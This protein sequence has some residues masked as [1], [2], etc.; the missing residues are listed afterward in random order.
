M[1]EIKDKLGLSLKT[2]MGGPQR[3]CSA[4]VVTRVKEKSHCP[5][6]DHINDRPWSGGLWVHSLEAVWPF[7][8][9]STRAL[10][11]HDGITADYRTV[12]GCGGWAAGGA[13][14]SLVAAML[15]W[16]VFP[17]GQMRCQSL[18]SSLSHSPCAGVLGLSLLACTR[19]GFA[20]INTFRLTPL[21]SYTGEV[22][23]V[24]RHNNYAAERGPSR[25]PSPARGPA[26]EASPNK[27]PLPRDSHTSLSAWTIWA[28]FSPSY[29]PKMA[30]ASGLAADASSS[31]FTSSPR[32]IRPHHF[33][34]ALSIPVMSGSS[35]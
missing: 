35:W 6:P 33:F 4:A 24:Q 15:E 5:F 17:R 30:G 13:G 18:L 1:S 28:P 3:G 21:Y 14:V 23:E 8:T 22:G 7:G 32:S 26:D 27:T 10:R 31:A 2:G 19:P 20:D 16:L 25:C 11:S 9:S 34:T 29:L 12:F